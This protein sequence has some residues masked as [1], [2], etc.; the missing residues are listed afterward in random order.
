[1]KDGASEDMLIVTVESESGSSDICSFS[2]AS[3]DLSASSLLQY[4]HNKN[5]M[6]SFPWL[7]DDIN[8]RTQNVSKEAI[9]ISI[10]SL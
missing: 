1:M 4:C 7:G 2:F 9:F 8:C 3:I 5:V 10:H 6:L